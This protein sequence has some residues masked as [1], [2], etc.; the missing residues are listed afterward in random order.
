MIQ[1]DC[2]RVHFHERLLYFHHDMGVPSN[3]IDGDETIIISNEQIFII[4][5]VHIW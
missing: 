4:N 2:Q 1:Q 3:L 5:G